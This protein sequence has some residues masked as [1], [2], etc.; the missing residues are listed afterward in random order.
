MRDNRAVVINALSRGGSNILWNILQSHPLLCSPIRE[1]GALFTE[2]N[3]L[4]LVRYLPAARAKRMAT[5]RI[6]RMLAGPYIRR[7]L[8]RWKLRNYQSPNNRTKY[9][10]IPYTLEEVKN[11]ILCFKGVDSDIDLNGLLRSL[12]EDIT[13]IGL[14]RNGYA[15][16][17]GWM[18]RGLSA[19]AAG[20]KY[21]SLVRRIL[22][23]QNSSERSILIKFE[24]MIR[25]PF[26]VARQVFHALEIEPADIPKIRLKAK[27]VLT[28]TGE[29]EPRFGVEGT[30]YWFGPEEILDVL[31]QEVNDRQE[32]ALKPAAR[33]AFENEAKGVLE[34]LGYLRKP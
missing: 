2:E 17:N 8:H 12:Y 1:T 20:R 24:E 19:K 4:P 31:D 25:D 21:S 6:A 30:K 22:D 7:S 3:V 14:V 11:S 5:W 29:H 16:C 13:Y 34:M 15:V 10:G 33:F 27:G 26:G 18:R 28:R 32:A 9:E 23:Q